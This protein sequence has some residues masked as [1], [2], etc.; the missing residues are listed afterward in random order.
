M[1]AV[2]HADPADAVFFRLVHGEPG[3]KAHRQVAKTIV[4]I[5]DCGRVVVFGNCDICPGIGA[6][7]TQAVHILP[8]AE[9]A[10]GVVAGEVRLDHQPGD[11]RS[12]V[13]RHAQPGKGGGDKP[14]N[15]GS[16]EAAVL[17]PHGGLRARSR[18]CQI[19]EPA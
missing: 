1:V 11:G 7:I 14:L 18:R 12:I 2:A 8:Q 3:G 15:I 13:F 16:S 5:D 9:R 4:A 6:A 10:M 17:S 19:R